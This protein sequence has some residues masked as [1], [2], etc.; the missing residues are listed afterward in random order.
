MFTDADSFEV[1]LFFFSSLLL[2]S[3]E[4]SDTKV[5]EPSIRA[6]LGT[7]SHFFEVGVLKLSTDSRML[8]HP[9]YMWDHHQLYQDRVFQP[10]DWANFAREWLRRNKIYRRILKYTS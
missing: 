5:Y 8:E 1:L 6:L 4:S 3:L 9:I 7:A 10:R 2:S